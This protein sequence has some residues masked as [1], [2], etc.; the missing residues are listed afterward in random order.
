MPHAKRHMEGFTKSG[1]VPVGRSADCTHPRGVG[2]WED[3][4]EKR[5]QPGPEDEQAS[6]RPEDTGEGLFE[7]KSI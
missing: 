7:D 1:G 3:P 4:G 6:N 5:T 2:V